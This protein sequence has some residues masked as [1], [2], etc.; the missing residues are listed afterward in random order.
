MIEI[1]SDG[2]SIK[3]RRN[4]VAKGAW[5]FV[6]VI[7]GREAHKQ[8]QFYPEG[9][10]S[11][12]MELLGAFH[13]L[14]YAYENYSDID[15]TLYCDSQYIV[16]GLNDWMH[17]WVKRDWRKSGSQEKIEHPE[18]WKD[19][20]FLNQLINGTYKWVRGHNE[21]KWNEIADELANSTLKNRSH[22]NVTK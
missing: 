15:L 12:K 5:A 18:L 4:A 8:S 11:G 9:G 7:E 19:F 20:Y 3:R 6:V 13:G 14:L 16:N 10:S 2:S 21:S 17:R 22:E 1:W